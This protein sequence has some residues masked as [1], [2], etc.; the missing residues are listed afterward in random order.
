MKPSILIVDDELSILT[1][2][3]KI[4]TKQGYEVQVCISAEKAV[5]IL[6]ESDFDLVLVDL[7]LK[8][9][10]NGFELMLWINENKPYLVEIVLSGTTK[11]EDVVKAVY[12]GA[13]D[14][15]LK[16][17]DSWEMFLHQINRAVEH[18][19]I[20]EYNEQLTKE[21]QKKNAELENRI[22][23]LELAYQLV[24]AQTEVFQQDL[25]KAERIQRTLLPKNIPRH[26]NISASVYF[27][28]L[29]R[30][31]GDLM[32]IFQL[33]ENH[34]GIYIADTSGHGIGSALVTTFLNYAFQP[35]YSEDSGEVKI[36]SPKIL[37]K[38]LNEKL[39][40]GPFGYEIFISLCYAIIDLQNQTIEICNAGHPTV[41]W[42]HNHSNMVE[43]IRIPAPAL[44]IVSGAKFT[45]MTYSW[46]WNDTFIF[47]TDGIL[48]LQDSENEQFTQQNLMELLEQDTGNPAEM[49][50]QL[51]E[52]LSKWIE[53]RLQRDDM[54]LI[55][56]ALKGQ[57][58][59]QIIYY[60]LQESAP[61]SISLSTRDV[62]YGIQKNTCYLKITGTGTWREAYSLY[63]FL[64]KLKEENKQV[65][66]WVLDFS[67]CTQLESTFLGVLHQLCLASEEKGSPQI[68]L[69][70]IARPLLKEFSELG[71]ADIF[72]HFLFESESLP[73]ELQPITMPTTQERLIDFILNAH[74]MLISADPSN[75]PR[76]EQL[77]T[78]LKEEKNKA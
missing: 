14:F 73:A 45:S 7:Y 69:Q 3:D 32:D 6:K 33:D 15:V 50:H 41:L 35:K 68:A 63:D 19:R 26:Q 70:N 61:L 76:F 43:V 47:Y 46:D 10:L 48:N 28:P 24:Q 60:P 58:N 56:F 51:D 53:Q 40:S 64:Q 59:P 37:L 29:N 38:N 78:L 5:Q 17:I 21:I 65:E 8:G 16:P 4:L 36:V 1:L 2:M 25:Q 39:V 71:L 75:A 77:I 27:H 20:K 55:W 18:K 52:K 67:E 13:Y 9:R 66:R 34:I 23:E 62:L 31:G 54:T 12:F 11:I 30:I 22:A 72:I 57:E 49:V 42:R 44:G 74:E